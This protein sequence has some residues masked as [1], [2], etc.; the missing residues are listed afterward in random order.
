MVDRAEIVIGDWA[1]IGDARAVQRMINALPEIT[2]TTRD[3]EVVRAFGHVQQSRDGTVLDVQV[4]TGSRGNVTYTTRPVFKGNIR[5]AFGPDRVGQTIRGERVRV[6]LEG[7]LN[8]NHFLMAQNIPQFFGLRRTQT[9]APFATAISEAYAQ[10]GDEYCLTDETNVLIGSNALYRYVLH[11]PVEAHLIDYI[12]VVQSFLGQELQSVGN[13]YG[14]RVVH[15]PY[16]S[17]R[18]LEFVWEFSH[19]HPIR[20]VENLELPMRAI[21][22]QSTR[23][24]ALVRGEAVRVLQDSFAIHSEMSS[25]CLMTLYAKT[26]KRVRFEVRMNDYAVGRALSEGRTS[27]GLSQLSNMFSE[28]R[29]WATD[30]FREALVDLERIHAPSPSEKTP[31]DFC[32]EVATILNDKSVTL[33]ILET[34]RNRGSLASPF[35]SPMK[36]A[37]ETLL[38]EHVLR[39][40]RSRSL[41]FVPRDQWV[42]AVNG[43]RSM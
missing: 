8:L 24:R 22:P 16:Y 42:A 9:I 31:I 12:T 5:H 23:H 21:G 1:L 29:S 6:G 33:S 10:Y 26:N 37:A 25:G 36:A 27:R 14:V 15:A 30:R 17:I 19:D 38:R 32:T 43:L 41:E 39:R 4:S 3:G 7:K 2:A 13:S 40:R 18:A 20:L 28:L 34:M 35:T 11:K